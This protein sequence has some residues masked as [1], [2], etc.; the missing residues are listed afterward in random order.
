MPSS[1]QNTSSQLPSTQ[2]SALSSFPTYPMTPSTPTPNEKKR[3]FNFIANETLDLSPS[4]KRTKILDAR[5]SGYDGGQC[6]L[7]S[8][9]KNTD[10][11]SQ[12]SQETFIGDN[13]EELDANSIEI[14][15][16][17]LENIPAYVKKLEIRKIAAEKSRDA[18][19]SKIAFLEAEVERYSSFAFLLVKLNYSI[20]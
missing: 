16:R 12:C 11:V 13:T 4:Q 7:S 10:S 5:T 18:K 20:G 15:L 19:A 17:S 14:L 8:F 3:G 9:L 2:E 6:L 1:S